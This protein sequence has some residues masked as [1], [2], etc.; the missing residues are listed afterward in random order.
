M[1][2][3]YAALPHDYLA[4]MAQLDDAEFGRLCRA[5]LR[6]SA[7]GESGELPGNERF[8][9]PRVI[10][11]EDRFQR[12]YDELTRVRSAA[13]KKG[14]AARWGAREIAED[15]KNNYTE[16]ETNTETKTETKTKTETQTQLDTEAPAGPLHAHGARRPNFEAAE[17][18]SGRKAAGRRVAFTPP[19]PEQVRDYVA[20]RG[21][22]VDPQIFWDYYQARGWMVG[23]APMRDW[24]AACRGAE[25]WERWQE[26]AAPAG[27]RRASPPVTP[28]GGP[29][30]G[31]CQPSAAAILAS[32]EFLDRVLAREGAAG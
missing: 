20:R 12:S 6:Y 4:E 11:Q 9:L 22:R 18:L 3:N 16:T 19:T 8:L 24:K 7:G 31:G 17:V 25:S 28:S 5:L 26:P 10:Q 32:S 14:M 2:R 13:G 30:P 15:N 29:G 27:A 21:S 23:N 1:A